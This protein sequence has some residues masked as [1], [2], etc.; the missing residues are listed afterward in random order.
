ME[1]TYE[2]REFIRQIIKGGAGALIV[3]LVSV[4]IFALCL[5][6]FGIGEGAIKPVNQVIK[7]LS[8]FV[9]C[10]FSIRGEKGFL[11]G[12]FIGLFASIFSALLFGLIAGGLSP[13]GV[14]IDALCGGIMGMIS[15]AIVVNLPLGRS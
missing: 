6:L 8:V 15:G 2:K 11:K 5:D 7:L 4:I 1:K 12:L 3:A 9:G 14:L 13:A 10:M